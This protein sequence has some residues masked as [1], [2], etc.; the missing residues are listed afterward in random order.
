MPQMPD[1]LFNPSMLSYT[2]GHLIVRKDQPLSSLSR[3]QSNEPLLLGYRLP[4]F[5]RPPVWSIE[6]KIRFL[7][8]AW[9]GYHLGCVVVNDQM[10]RNGDSRYDLWL[11]DGQQRLTAIRDYLDDVFP[12]FGAKYSE[13][14]ER[15]HRRFY[16]ITFAFA[17]IKE[18]SLR[19]LEELYERMNYGGTPHIK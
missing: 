10:H 8:S 19:R 3:H 1:R 5:Q 2:M 6:Q 15:D 11:I 4:P 9:Q 12:V 16:M 14:S 17:E 18:S 7:E 13:L